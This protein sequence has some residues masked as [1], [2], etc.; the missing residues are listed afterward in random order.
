MNNCDYQIS[1]E[2]ALLVAAHG[3]QEALGFIRRNFL[4]L[5]RKISGRKYQENLDL[6]IDF[7]E[8]IYA[9]EIALHHAISTYNIGNVPFAAFAQVVIERGINSVIRAHRSPTNTMFRTAISFDGPI[10]DEDDSLT[11]SDIVGTDDFYTSKTFETTMICHLQD[12]I[13]PEFSDEEFLLIKRKMEG[14]SFMQIM[15][16]ENI[17]RRRLE[18]TLKKH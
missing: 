1:N 10:G 8:L 6:H 11:M 12:L 14:Y 17:S 18:A 9:G 7:D 2:E 13:L 15:E 3:D 5:I 4:N 16:Q